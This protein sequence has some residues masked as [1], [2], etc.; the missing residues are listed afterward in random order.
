[1]A[2]RLCSPTFLPTIEISHK[3]CIK[4][5][6]ITEIRKCFILKINK[7]QCIQ[8][9]MQLKQDSKENVSFSCVYKKRREA[10]KLKI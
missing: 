9:E 10:E 7:I 8:L 2:K 1:M 5:E 6:I 3:S 4:E